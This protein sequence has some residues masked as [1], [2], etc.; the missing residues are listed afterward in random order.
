LLSI[1]KAVT[2]TTWNHFIILNTDVYLSL[3]ASQSP[4]TT[5]AWRRTHKPSPILSRIQTHPKCL[6]DGMC[7]VVTVDSSLRMTSTY[8]V[9]SPPTNFAPLLSLAPSSIP[10]PLLYLHLYCIPCGAGG[11]SF[12]TPRSVF[13]LRFCT[14]RS[15]SPPPNAPY[16][17]AF[18]VS[19]L[20]NLTFQ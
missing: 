9:G 18:F 15:G 19:S 2:L 3:V 1:D 7:P 13:R 11:S 5:R 10:P 8:V 16:F 17:G 4:M 6:S 12:D 20:T 14:H